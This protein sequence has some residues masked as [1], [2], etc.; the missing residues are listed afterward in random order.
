[1]R[2]ENNIKISVF[3]LPEYEA[4]FKQGPDGWW[5][6][7]VCFSMVLDPERV[8]WL[9]G[10]TFI[11][12]DPHVR[13]REGASIINNSIAI[14]RG[15]LTGSSESL[16]FYWQKEVDEDQ[17]FF[18]DGS[19]DSFIWPLSSVLIGEKLFFIV[20]RVVQPD[21]TDT[22]GFE[23]IGNEVI[24]IENPDADPADWQMENQK[25]PWDV[26]RVCFGS[27]VLTGDNHL[28][29][30]GFIKEENT[31]DEERGLIIA[32]VPVFSQS[33]LEKVDN[34]EFHTGEYGTWSSNIGKIGPVFRRA[35]TEFS[36]VHM[37]Q[38]HKYVMT[39]YLWN[40]RNVITL[41]FSD[42]PYGPFSEPR[43]VYDCPET[44]W[45]Q[46]YICYTARAH[47]ELA[48]SK[49]EMIVSYVANS[50]VFLE[51]VMDLRIYYPR[52]IKIK[53]G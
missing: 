44:D 16:N 20:L 23:I 13:G 21:I 1:V 11:Q 19:G 48:G 31:L 22:S 52:F 40:P 12:S 5:G 51:C 46:H 41:R 49:N 15:V 3:P 2:N 18:V 39:G 53:I 7:D 29:I 6:S 38:I 34:W 10:D 42:T 24:R 30:Y 36:V 4:P 26:N 25:M 17:S 28:Y 9:F 14:Q 50:R 43:I 27:T 45:S 33:N 47:P 37:P 8:L 35:N 32:R